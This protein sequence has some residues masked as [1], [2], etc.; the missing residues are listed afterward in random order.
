MKIFSDKVFPRINKL[1][2]FCN[3]AAQSDK[4]LPMLFNGGKEMEL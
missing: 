4:W 1:Q 3:Y 2:W